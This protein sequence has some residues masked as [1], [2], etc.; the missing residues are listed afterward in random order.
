MSRRIVRRVVTAGRKTSLG[1][2]SPSREF[3]VLFEDD[4]ETGYFY[5]LQSSRKDN[6][7]LDMVNLYTVDPGSDPVRHDEMGIVWSQDGS[8]VMLLLNE[9]PQAVFDFQAKRGY[10]RTNDPN[11]PRRERDTWHPEDHSWSDAVCQWFR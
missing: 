1:S 9:Y 2:A 8:K 5:A 11:V 6:Q 3:C 4:G 10:C 7:I